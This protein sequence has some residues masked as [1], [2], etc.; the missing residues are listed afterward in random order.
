M[1]ARV[2]KRA[3][4]D[5]D[6]SACLKE[7]PPVTRRDRRQRSQAVC[8]TCW[9]IFRAKSPGRLRR[10]PRK[11]SAPAASGTPGRPCVV[12]ACG[13]RQRPRHA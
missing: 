8:R 1:V 7:R 4:E 12:S 3:P 5:G 9:R 2:V 10:R 6:A 11:W 13:P